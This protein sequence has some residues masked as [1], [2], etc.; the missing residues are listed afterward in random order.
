MSVCCDSTYTIEAT[1]KAECMVYRTSA[2]SNPCIA[3]HSLPYTLQHI[4]H[5]N[6]HQE[7]SVCD[8]L[9]INLVFATRLL[10]ECICIPVR[11]THKSALFWARICISQS[12]MICSLMRHRRTTGDIF[13][14]TSTTQS[15]SSLVHSTNRRTFCLLYANKST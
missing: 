4:R 7:A 2:P 1:T 8:H 11:S 5:E 13:Q 12:V 10:Y 14:Q 6:T 15:V 9:R 3:T